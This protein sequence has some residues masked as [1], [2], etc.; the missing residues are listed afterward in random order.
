MWLA[1]QFQ[2]QEEF[3]VE[4]T[5][6]DPVPIA[7]HLKRLILLRSVLACALAATMGVAALGFDVHFP[8]GGMAAVLLLL[9]AANLLARTRLRCAHRVRETELFL[10]LLLD[11]G[12]LS[13]L[14]YLSGGSTNPFVSLYLL[15]L[16]IAATTLP[17]RF[18]WSM[19]GLTASCYALLFFFYLPLPGMHSG[20][21]EADFHLH[22][23]GM[24]INFLL[25]AGVIAFFVVR[26][27]QTIRSRD[28][29]LARQKESALRNERVVALGTLAAGAAH[30]LG[31]PLSTMAVILG[32]MTRD[33]ADK[34]NLAGDLTTLRRQVDSCKQTITRMVA[35][36]GQARA[37]GGG[38]Q[39][40]DQFLRETLER[41]RLLRPSVSLTEH[42]R[43]P[44]PAPTILTEQTLRQ[45][46]L[47]LLNNAADA[48]PQNVE[49]DCSWGR[50]RL[51]LEIRD[52][53][54][55]LSGE[56]LMRASRGFFSTKPQG[57][58]NGIGLLL[59]RATLERLGGHLR[60]EG[61]AGG[62]VCTML[63]L[64]LGGLAPGQPG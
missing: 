24:W 52:R 19:A 16:V 10:H 60:L 29:E 2:S 27:A 58:G 31:T 9:P 20:H 5:A 53:G 33:Y 30:E 63:E 41:W 32:D 12:V 3:P 54:P 47:N 64:P 45:A 35:A 15:P 1:L 26:M 50:G 34:P 62:G 51:R 44:A 8:W 40:V 14:L 46:I 18:A 43:G 11:V 55:G 21:G 13:A 38:A 25:S 6:F 42:L 23:V 4:R 48:S 59:A 39:P 7:E 56:T 36:A 17:P 57:E 22:L 28:A 49:L 61:R 37:E